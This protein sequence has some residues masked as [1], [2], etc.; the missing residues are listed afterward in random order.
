[1]DWRRCSCDGILLP[2]D[3]ATFSQEQILTNREVITKAWTDEG[4][5][6]NKQRGQ[7]LYE[8]R[9][10]FGDESAMKLRNDVRLE[11]SIPTGDP[12]S[13]IFIDRQNRLIEIQLP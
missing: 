6:K 12:D 9:I 2:E 8:M 1:L 13:W 4:R 11:D 5:I 3:T 10:Y 7:F